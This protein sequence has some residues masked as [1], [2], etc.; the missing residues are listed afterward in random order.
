M[1]TKINMCAKSSAL[2]ISVVLDFYG[3]AKDYTLS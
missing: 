3:K 1:V 2:L